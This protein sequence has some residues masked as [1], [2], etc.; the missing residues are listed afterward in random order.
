MTE[1]SKTHFNIQPNLF[2][3]YNFVLPSLGY[4]L[5]DACYDLGDNTW[6]AR[7][8]SLDFYIY[9]GVNGVPIRLDIV[10]NG[11]GMGVKTLMESYRFAADT[12]HG[13]GELGKFGVGGT[14]ACISMATKKTTLTKTID[15]ELLIAS[16]D[17]SDMKNNDSPENSAYLRQPTENEKEQFTAAVG[18]HGTIIRIE[19]FDLEKLEYQRAGVWRNALVKNL[20]AVYRPYLECGKKINVHLVDTINP[21]KSTTTAVV[22]KDPLYWDNDDICIYKFEDK[23][24]FNGS[25]IKI[26]FS[27]LNNDAIESGNKGYRE[28][29]IYV[30]RNNRQI[31]AGEDLGLWKKNPIYN[32]GRLEISFNEELDEVFQIN[33]QKNK[34]VLAQKLGDVLKARIKPFRGLCE[35][36][37]RRASSC[38]DK[39]VKSEAAFCEKLRKASALL[40]IP[41]KKVTR[42][43]KDLD[44]NDSNDKAKT[45]KT[46]NRKNNNKKYQ[47][48]KELR[49]EHVNMPKVREAFWFS[50]D[51]DLQIKTVINDANDFIKTEY[52][53]A[54]VQTKTALKKMFWA[55]CLSQL[56]FIDTESEMHISALHDEF[57]YKL[58][59]IQNITQEK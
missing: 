8:E 25:E 52:L 48:N 37:Y 31:I 18:N 53:G 41:K 3:M 54:S 32:T 13:P 59:T 36:K 57:S 10:D 35:Q 34:L 11:T 51:D 12:D 45:K 16:L 28:Q 30:N 58:S 14:I 46:D 47:S 55:H 50:Y 5:L 2:K 15:G 44:K 43:A 21:K 27:I 9:K 4:R 24:E 38:D 20:G 39:H 40:D 49:F 29:G 42:K 7:A 1:I 26:R 17:I 22:A 23:F 19:N 33:A 6:D 56:K